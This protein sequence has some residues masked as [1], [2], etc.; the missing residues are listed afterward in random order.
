MMCIWFGCGRLRRRVRHLEEKVEELARAVDELA[1]GIVP[2]EEL[3]RFLGFKVGTEIVVYTPSAALRGVLLSVGV[4]VLQ[5]R[6]TAGDLAVIP[7]SKVTY[8]Q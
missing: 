5:L 3:R 4:D 8:V 6:E 7:F 1:S 2:N